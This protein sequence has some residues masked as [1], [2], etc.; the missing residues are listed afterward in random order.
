MYIERAENPTNLIG[1]KE[2]MVHILKPLFHCLTEIRQ[3]GN[4]TQYQ[5]DTLKCYIIIVRKDLDILTGKY[6]LGIDD[7]NFVENICKLIVELNLLI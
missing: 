6:E 3:Q 5:R 4:I 7:D 1:M 2:K